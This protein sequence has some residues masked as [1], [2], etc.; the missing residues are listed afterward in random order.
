MDRL[1]LFSLRGAPG[2]VHL[3]ALVPRPD[4]GGP[5]PNSGARAALIGGQGLWGPRAV[6]PRVRAGPARLALA[7][8]ARRATRRHQADYRARAGRRRWGRLCEQ[9]TDPPAVCP[10]TLGS[11]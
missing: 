1:L 9:G 4:Y 11:G 10:L 5:K 8:A 2:H 6:T 3:G 7:P